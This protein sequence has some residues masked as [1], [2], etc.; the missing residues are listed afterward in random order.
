V[1]SVVETERKYLSVITSGVPMGGG[2]GC[3]NSVENR[4]PIERVSEGR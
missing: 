3:T 4:G 1:G 2:E